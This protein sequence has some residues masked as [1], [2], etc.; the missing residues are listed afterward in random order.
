MSLSPADRALCSVREAVSPS[1]RRP[2]CPWSGHIRTHS[3]LPSRTVTLSALTISRQ[4]CSRARLASGGWPSCASTGGLRRADIHSSA[5]LRHHNIP[6]HHLAIIPA[7][8]CTL[9]HLLFLLNWSTLLWYPRVARQFRSSALC[10]FA[11]CHLF[12]FRDP[13]VLRRAGPAEN[14]QPIPLADSSSIDKRLRT[15]CQ[16]I[17][18][19]DCCLP[20]TNLPSMNSIASE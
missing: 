12:P 10:T 6:G 4:F 16:E 7:S 1:A 2:V 18:I 14:I 19:T 13:H 8:I 15:D 9:R 20:Q 11:P 3:R 5:T 17:S